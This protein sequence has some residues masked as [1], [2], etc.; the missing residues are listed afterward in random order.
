[1]RRSLWLGGLGAMAA[2][3]LACES[4]IGADF[5]V[6]HLATCV[7]AT[8]PE[9]PDGGDTGSERDFTAVVYSIDWGDND[10]AANNP[11]SY[12]IGYNLDGRC[13]SLF[14]TPVCEPVPWTH[15]LIVDGP[16]GIDN[17]IGLM[18]HDQAAAF[19]FRE[20]TSSFFNK[21]IQSG[22]QAPPAMFR[23]SGYSGLAYDGQVT[24]EWFV[25]AAATANAPAPDFNAAPEFA[26][27]PGTAD[28]TDGGG[29]LESH[30]VDRHAYVS[31]YSLVAHF[32]GAPIGIS[33]V[34][35]KTEDSLFTAQLETQGGQWQMVGG[36]VAGHVPISELFDDMALLSTTT[37]LG[38]V[39]TV[40]RNTPTVY[41]KVKTWLCSHTDS[42]VP[43]TDSDNNQ[44]CNDLSFGAAFV[45]RAAQ[46]GSLAP[47]MSTPMLC[48]KGEDPKDDNCDTPPE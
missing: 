16:N 47:A 36:I 43:G 4:I 2:F 5:G 26:V 19:G 1:M 23:V 27:A 6:Q 22:T 24:V 48:A 34:P 45:A 37:S 29:N 46:I 25:P 13:T 42:L 12:S 35:I 32:L 33:N 11:R 39:V 30:F 21:N 40:C 31:G 38:P 41:S 9:P 20:F 8:P 15:Q 3:A 17:A 10:D 14:D 44:P 28:P 7:P 18:L